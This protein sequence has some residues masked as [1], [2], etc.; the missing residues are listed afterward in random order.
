MQIRAG[1]GKIC[2]MNTNTMPTPGTLSERPWWAVRLPL[3]AILLLLLAVLVGMFAPTP[4][5]EWVFGGET[6]AF[7]M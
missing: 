1:E 3:L 6:V 2:D 4:L 7:F 5:N